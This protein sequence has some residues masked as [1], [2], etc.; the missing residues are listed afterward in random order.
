[1]P[2]LLQRDHAHERSGPV[3]LGL[4][5]VVPGLIRVVVVDETATATVRV[6]PDRPGDERGLPQVL[7]DTE[8]ASMPGRMTV[9]V[10]ARDEKGR[11]LRTITQAL[12]APE[13][14]DGP[15]M[16]APLRITVLAPAGSSIVLDTLRANVL[17]VGHGLDRAQVRTVQGDVDLE[18]AES[19][20]VST[21]SGKVF[22]SARSTVWAHSLTGTIAITTTPTTREVKAHSIGGRVRYTHRSD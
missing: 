14:L 17:C 9:T 15:R 18:D 20:V 5:S 8:M 16:C 1:M 7:R 10:P 21:V 2:S 19:A 3:V 6:A 12:S 11:L 22:V 4:T 13:F